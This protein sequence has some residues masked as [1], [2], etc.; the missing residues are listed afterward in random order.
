[1]DDSTENEQRRQLAQVLGVANISV[2]QLWLRYFGSGGSVG[3][4]EVDAYVQGLI[5]LPVLQ[6]DLLAL[7]T[8][9]LV[10]ELPALPRAP[11]AEDIELRETGQQSVSQDAENRRQDAD[12]GGMSEDSDGPDA[13]DQGLGGPSEA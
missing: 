3:E 7:A 8:N 12:G 9:E 1:M 5:S 13:E 4:Y 2:S 10:D 6:R 11:F